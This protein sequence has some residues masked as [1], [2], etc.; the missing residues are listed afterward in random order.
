MR[1]W[2]RAILLQSLN[3]A[4]NRAR[5]ARRFMAEKCHSAVY[6]SVWSN[7]HITG[8]TRRSHFTVINSNGFILV[9][10]I[11]HHK[12][13]AAQIARLRV[14]NRQCKACCHSGIHRITTSLEHR[15]P[16]LAGVTFLARHHAV[17]RKCGMKLG[18]IGNQGCLAWLH[19]LC[20][21][22]ETT[23]NYRNRCERDFIKKLHW[24]L[25]RNTQ[26]QNS[27]Y[28]YILGNNILRQILCRAPTAQRQTNKADHKMARF[29]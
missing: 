8:S 17:F 7:E 9:S 21:P 5:R 29:Q 16:C 18:I 11:D 23:T 3:Q 24:A 12:A 19:T 10:K 2:Q 13:A 14:R 4:L 20:K 22:C 1:E 27:L 28:P 15:Q 6:I 26:D 25:L